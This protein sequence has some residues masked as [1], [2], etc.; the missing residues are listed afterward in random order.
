M[1]ADPDERFNATCPPACRSCDGS[2]TIWTPDADGESA[3]EVACP[4]PVHASRDETDAEIARRLGL[5]SPYVLGPLAGH[6]PG[7]AEYGHGLSLTSVHGRCCEAWNRAI[8]AR[9]RAGG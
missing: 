4:D 8:A 7:S 2:G 6:C 1:S 3:Y 9:D 5:S